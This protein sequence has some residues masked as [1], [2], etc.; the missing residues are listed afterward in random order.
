M[1]C[2]GDNIDVNF[3]INPYWSTQLVI[4]FTNRGPFAYIVRNKAVVAMYTIDGEAG[5]KTHCNLRLVRTNIGS[6]A[7]EVRDCAFFHACRRNPPEPSL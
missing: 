1:I 7:M 5:T 4:V 2:S 3:L 6:N